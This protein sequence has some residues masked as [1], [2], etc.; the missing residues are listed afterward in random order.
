MTLDAKSDKDEIINTE[1]ALLSNEL[2]LTQKTNLAELNLEESEGSDIFT[3]TIK[4]TT[5]N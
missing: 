5:K 1:A 3:G 4:K 2:I